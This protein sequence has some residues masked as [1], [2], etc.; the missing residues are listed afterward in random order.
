VQPAGLAIDWPPLV[1]Y[2]VSFSVTFGADLNSINTAQLS[3]TLKATIAQ[4][5]DGVSAGDVFVTGIKPG[6]VVVDVTIVAESEEEANGIAD[7]LKEKGV[8]LFVS[9]LGF[10]GISDLSDPS[11]STPDSDTPVGLIVGATIGSIAAVAFVAALVFWL[12]RRRARVDDTNS[13]PLLE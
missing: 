1:D 7:A 3:T 2:T 8:G 4:E 10:G 12:V 13:S 11:I 6:S 5:I 9:M